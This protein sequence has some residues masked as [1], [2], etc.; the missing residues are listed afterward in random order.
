MAE[1]NLKKARAAHDKAKISG[2]MHSEPLGLS[3]SEV[4]EVSHFYKTIV[5]KSFAIFSLTT[6]GNM[7]AYLLY[8]M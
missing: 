3:L 2:R 6:F 8:L 7:M 5:L 4:A 1:T